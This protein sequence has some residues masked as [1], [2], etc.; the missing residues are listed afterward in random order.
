MG[1]WPHLPGYFFFAAF[2]FAAELD[3]AG[4]CP[5]FFFA[6]FGCR[7]M[8]G[9]PFRSMTGFAF[10]ST[11][12]LGVELG[13]GVCANRKHP[14]I[15]AVH[16][17]PKSFFISISPIHVFRFLLGKTQNTGK[18]AHAAKKM[19]EFASGRKP[20][21]HSDCNRLQPYSALLTSPEGQ[22]RFYFVLG[23]ASGAYD[24]WFIPSRNRIV[25]AME[26]R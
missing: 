19:L 16:R 8:Y 2:C 24:I 9:F 10:R 18:L 20:L 1:P 11:I 15:A 22:G 3:E 17:T 25:S 12:G 14:A 7:S 13:A 5:G 4:V 21:S 6:C 26:W 23:R